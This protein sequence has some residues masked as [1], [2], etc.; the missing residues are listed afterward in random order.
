M[1]ILIVDD[2]EENVYLLDALFRGSGFE[3]R[4]AAHGAEALSL[5]LNE[6]VDI[7]ISDI[8]MPVMD[9]FTFCRECRRLSLLRTIP[10]IFYTATYTDYKDESYAMSLGADRFVLKPQDPDVLVT[11][12]EEVLQ[13]AKRG[14]RTVPEIDV[15]EV[16]ELREYNAVLIRKLED[17]MRQT[18]ENERNLKAYVQKLEALLEERERAA[19]ALR[20]GEER[21]RLL[22]ESSMDAILLT[23]PD[24]SIFAANHAACEMFQSTEEEICRQRRE[25]LVDTTDPNL[26]RLLEERDRTGRT[27]GE[28]TFKRSDG[29]RFPAEISAALFTTSHGELRSSMC[30]R[31]VTER[32]RNEDAIRK[33]NDDLERRVRERTAELVAAN[34]DLEAFGSSVSHD[35]R[36]PLRAIVGYSTIL[37]DSYRHLLDAE[38]IRIISIVGERAKQLSTM[39]DD[40]LSFSRIGRASFHPC[41]VDIDAMVRRVYQELTTDSMRERIT[42]EVASLPSV[43]CDPSLMQLVWTNLLQNAIKFSSKK[44]RARI[45]VR[46]SRVGDEI[47]FSVR[48]DGAGFDMQYAEN[49][50]QVFRRLHSEREFEGTGVGL[51]IVERI[52]ERHGG[53]VWAYGEVGSGAT[54]SFSLREG[55]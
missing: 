32:K 2:K 9:G 42:F 33:L 29:S 27:R 5:V 10:F 50:F 3:T 55:G 37:H 7:I 14:Q 12:V 53:K 19:K 26:P 40:L 15:P 24:G 18:E 1:K 8:L 22:L 16:V 4:T 17:K 31:D 13:E 46:S 49:I 25:G 47:T 45:E 35:L 54:I 30:I 21:Y 6:P 51:S 48:D 23:A 52:V 43:M 38:G 20:E 44:E 36:V 41:L 11:I 34:R 28:L 39:I